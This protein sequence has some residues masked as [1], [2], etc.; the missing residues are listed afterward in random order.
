MYYIMLF[1]YGDRSSQR[2]FEARLMCTRLTFIMKFRHH[3]AYVMHHDK[4]TFGGVYRE[5]AESFKAF[6][7]LGIGTSL[8]WCMQSVEVGHRV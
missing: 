8:V 4:L 7:S 1:C 2:G 5:M 6:P 3:H